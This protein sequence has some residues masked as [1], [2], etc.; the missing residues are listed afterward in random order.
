MST[1]DKNAFLSF[2]LFMQPKESN[3]FP[4]FQFHLVDL[5]S[6]YVLYD[7]AK[8][9]EFQD[10]QYQKDVWHKSAKTTKKLASIISMFCFWKPFISAINMLNIFLLVMFPLT[11]IDQIYC[12]NMEC[13]EEVLPGETYF[14]LVLFYFIVQTFL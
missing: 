2:I 3:Y 6:F 11:I 4:Y 7:I 8:D 10:M 14:Y 1:Q 12:L 13:V 9:E 5:G